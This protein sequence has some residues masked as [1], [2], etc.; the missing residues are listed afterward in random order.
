MIDNKLAILSKQKT[1]ITQCNSIP[2]KERIEILKRLREL[3]RKNQDN[4][5]QALFED[6]HKNHAE[7]YMTE[8]G[9]TLS[10]ISYCIKHIKSWSKTRRKPTSVLLF[11]SKAF[12]YPQAKGNILIISPW[13][14]PF[15]LS[16]LPLVG[17][18]SAGNT[19]IL[20]PSSQSKA[21]NKLLQELINSNFDNKQI[22]C[23]NG[24]KELSSEILKQ[25]VDHLFFT[26]SYKT[27][28]YLH[29]ICSKNLISTTFELGGKSPLIIDKDSNLSIAA[30]RVCL[31]K[32]INCG[33]TCIAP[34]Y[35]FV[36][37][38]VKE[39]FIN[40]LKE[41]IISFFGIKASE[42]ENYGRI[43]NQKQF[44][45]LKNLLSQGEIIFGGNYNEQNNYIS[46]TLIKPY[47]LNNTLMEEEIF[48]PILPILE[49]K[50]IESVVEYINQRPRPLALYYFGTKNANIIKQ[51]I[52]GG[53]CINDAIMHIIP[54]NLPF[55]GIGQSG[56]GAYHGKKSFDTFSHYKSV[57]KTHKN[58]EFKIKYPPYTSLKQR[59]IKLL[60]EK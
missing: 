43:I 29:S 13:N 7:A 53:V 44:L 19:V 37:K 28:Q 52:S 55:G 10:E 54:H 36:H 15:Q 5:K 20:S 25:G 6:L 58:F 39:E 38:E 3:I 2:I 21:T 41:N 22:F 48:G 33:Q 14:Y 26:G 30:K 50:N 8:I 47:E 46:P 16:I 49:F 4:I 24:D 31:G 23:T 11:P 57:L 35:L 59:I 56:M 9:I 27:A 12:I 18:I 51:T 32:F 40:L 42:S 45:R 34:D 17:A 1:Y 60:M